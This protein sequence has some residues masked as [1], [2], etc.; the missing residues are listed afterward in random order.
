MNCIPSFGKFFSSSTALLKIFAKTVLFSNSAQA[1]AK[2]LSHVQHLN[3]TPFV[4]K[5]NTECFRT[6]RNDR[7]GQAFAVRG[8]AHFFS[9][10][11]RPGAVL[12]SLVSPLREIFLS[13]SAIERSV[14]I[15]VK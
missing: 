7:Y 15:S 8:L 12:R 1:G 6:P 4:V 10:F 14:L 9:F 2:S 11:F 13:H 5:N 3:L